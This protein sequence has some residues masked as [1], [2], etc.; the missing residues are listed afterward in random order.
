MTMGRFVKVG[1]RIFAFEVVVGTCL[2]HTNT[3]ACS[4]EGIWRRSGRRVISDRHTRVVGDIWR[5]IVFWEIVRARGHYP[6]A[7]E[8]GVI[9]L[10]H[11]SEGDRDEKARED[12]VAIVSLVHRIF[13]K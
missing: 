3:V 9:D 10:V 13:E 11:E 7:L 4:L 2:G 5:V 6:G 8:V 1:E 12:W